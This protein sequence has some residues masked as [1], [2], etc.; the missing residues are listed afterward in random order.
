MADTAKVPEDYDVDYAYSP[1]GVAV[2][3]FWTGA[4]AMGLMGFVANCLVSHGS[5]IVASSIVDGQRSLLVN[6]AKGVLEG[7]VLIL[8]LLGLT[9]LLG[10][11]AYSFTKSKRSTDG[12]QKF[13]WYGSPVLFAL[14]AIAAM[15]Y[16]RM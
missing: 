16:N 4:L 11:T 2:T 14:L 12:L 13:A 1:V 5:R 6:D 3:T 7:I 8:T 10:V 9:I 15:V